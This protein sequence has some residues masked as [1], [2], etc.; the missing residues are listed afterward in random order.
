MRTT[1]T[2]YKIIC[3]LKWNFFFF[4]ILAGVVRGWGPGPR[5]QSWA[6]HQDHTVKQHTC[7]NILLKHFNKTLRYWC[8]FSM[9][10][11]FLKFEFFF[12]LSGVLFS[13]EQELSYCPEA[14]SQIDR[15]CNKKIKNKYLFHVQYLSLSHLRF[16]SLSP[17]L[18]SFFVLP[19]S[20]PVR[21]KK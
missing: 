2:A 15:T 14:C 16:V 17:L 3:N 10:F 18:A 4:D 8:F 6:R 9:Y 5:G 12:D 20:N 13:R 1:Q 21:F 7:K 19:L 11:H